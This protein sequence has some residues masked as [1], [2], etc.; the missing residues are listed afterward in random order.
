MSDRC[1]PNGQMKEATKVSADLLIVFNW[2]VFVFSD[3]GF[4]WPAV[5]VSMSDRRQSGQRRANQTCSMSST[6]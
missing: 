6:V 1:R 2:D 4:N 5:V 3:D